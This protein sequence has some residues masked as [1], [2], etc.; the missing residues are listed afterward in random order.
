[1]PKKGIH[2]WAAWGLALSV[3]TSATPAIAQKGPKVAPGKPAPAPAAKK[4]DPKDGKAT[5]PDQ[6]P[7]PVANQNVDVAAVRADLMASD[8]DKAATAAGKLGTTKQ[9]AALDALLDGLAMGLHPTVTKAALK[10]VAMHADP[11]SIDVVLYY[12]DNR[13]AD[14]RALAIAALAPFDDKRVHAA[15]MEAFTDGEKPVRAAACKVA[16][17]RKDKTAADPL[18]ALL[19]K[20]D[21]ATV[22]ALAAIATPE[23]ARRLGELRDDAPPA[24]LAETLGA[25]LL[26][27][28]MGKEETYVQIVEALGKI[29][30]EE[31]VVA[32]SAYMDAVPEKPPRL[33]RRRASEIVAER[34]GGG[35]Q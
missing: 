21:E 26:R 33:S 1:M 23:L 8:P 34:I 11:K 29:P 12:A 17:V 3:A 35:G 24:L 2:R 13:N 9:P 28:D 7:A 15:V 25:I 5:P 30:G 14:V 22:A 16:E 10:S 32:L 18:I 27:K 20:G 4:K 31:A 19:E 6:P